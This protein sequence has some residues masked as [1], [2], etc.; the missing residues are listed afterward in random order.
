MLKQKE[1]KRVT[2]IVTK[3]LQKKIKYAILYVI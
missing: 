1:L 3:L 2:L